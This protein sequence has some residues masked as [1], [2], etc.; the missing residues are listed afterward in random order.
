[1]LMDFELLFRLYRLHCHNAVFMYTAMA[2][3]LLRW[4]TVLKKKILILHRGFSLRSDSFMFF[5]LS[6]L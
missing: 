1:M 5:L 4:G 2:A 3:S 6:F